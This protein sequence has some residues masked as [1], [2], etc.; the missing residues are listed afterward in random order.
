MKLAALLVVTTSC[1]FLV[2]EGPGNLPN[3]PDRYARCTDSNAYPVVDSVFAAMASMI[4]I[5]AAINYH[6][7]NQKPASD[8]ARIAGVTIGGGIGTL[9]VASAIHGFRRVAACK[10]SHEEYQLAGSP[11]PPPPAP[12]L[13]GEGAACVATSN[14][15]SGLTCASNLCVLLPPR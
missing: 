10:R 1:S 3:P 7:A 14:C 13:G 2:V 4:F 12:V 11:A 9:A 5:G 6:D 15:L 8:E